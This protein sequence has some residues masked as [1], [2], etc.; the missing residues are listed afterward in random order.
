MAGNRHGATAEAAGLKADRLRSLLDGSAEG[1]TA[2]EADRVFEALAA[3]AIADMGQAL[4]RAGISASIRRRVRDRGLSVEEA[5]GIAGL[6]A[7]VMRG[8]VERGE[9]RG[10]SIERLDEADE[11]YDGGMGL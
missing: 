9:T 4:V 7:D 11:R 1:W 8:I 10:L 3:R 2:R 5:A 6:D